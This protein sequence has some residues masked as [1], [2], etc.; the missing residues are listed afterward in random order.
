MLI[1]RRV[2]DTT[3][4]IST[5]FGLAETGKGLPVKNMPLFAF[6]NRKCI[7]QS[8]SSHSESIE[9]VRVSYV[10]RTWTSNGKEFLFAR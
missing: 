4:D 10:A 2:V 1:K 9:N 5:G 7:R 8:C 3:F 6:W